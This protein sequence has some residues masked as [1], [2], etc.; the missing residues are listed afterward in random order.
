MCASTKITKYQKP[1]ED[2]IGVEPQTSLKI[3]SNGADVL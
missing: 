3:S 2:K 1:L